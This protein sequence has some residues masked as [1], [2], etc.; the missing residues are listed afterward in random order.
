MQ[1]LDLVNSPS[2]PVK[3]APPLLGGK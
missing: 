2:V 1:V 3:K